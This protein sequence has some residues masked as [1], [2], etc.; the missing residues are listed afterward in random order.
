MKHPTHLLTGRPW[1]LGATVTEEGVNFALF[2]AH[3]TQVWLCLFDDAGRETVRLPLP[4][5]TEDVWHGLLPGAGAGLTYGYRVEGPHAPEHGHRFNPAK[6]LLDPYARRLAGRFVWSDDHLDNDA[7]NARY[8]VRAVVD[9]SEFDWRGDRPPMV[10][11]ED[12]V[13]YEVH[14][15]GATMMHPEVPPRDRGRYRGLASPAFVDHLKRIGVTAVNLLPVHQALDE[16]PLVE[17]GLVNYWGYNTLAFFAPDARFAEADPVAEFREMVRGLHEAGIEVILDVVYN[18]TAEGDHRGP[19]LSFRGIDNACYYRLLPNEPQHYENL[20]GT[21]NALDASHPRVMQLVLDSLRYWAQE[22]HVDGF[23]FDLATVLGRKA[24]HRGSAFVARAALFQAIAQDPVLARVKLIA[25]PWDLGPGGYQLGNF[26][27]GWSEWNDRYRDQVRSFWVR[28]AVYRGEIAS[29]IAGSRDIFGHHR[30]SPTASINYVA[31]HDGFTL[32]DVVSYNQRHNEA[33]GEDNRDGV[34]ENHS[35]N[36][37]VE[38]PTTL[39]AI[40]ALRARL[41][42]ALLATLFLSQGVPMLLG[43]DEI[44]RTQG[45]NNNAYCQDGPVS[46]FDWAH[47]DASL[48]AFVA[49]LAALRRR[50]PQLRRHT[51][52][53]GREDEKGRRDIIWLNRRGEEMNERQW[54]EWG[55]YAFGFV[56]GPMSASDAAAAGASP[57]EGAEESPELLVLLNGEASDWNMPIPAGEWRPVLDTGQRDGEPDDTTPVSGEWLLKARSLALFERAG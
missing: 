2:S 25:E 46:W 57:A 50:Y 22:M 38:G 55:R 41:K 30:R 3:A 6:L 35:W 51:W 16:R 13:L 33:N 7:D 31:S 24:P 18:H 29:R 4:R 54:G 14:V 28:K 27:A 11:M 15:K 9:A 39:L 49:K 32:H 48:A 21:G 1:P 10:P 20:T 42:R 53:E 19:I 52:L 26:P 40:T 34:A 17:R 56:L 44:G 5:R 43:G 23:R 45:G 8:T 37:G 36:C 12:S 47:A